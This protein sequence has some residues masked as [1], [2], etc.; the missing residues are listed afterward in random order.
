[1]NPISNE[2]LPLVLKITAGA[3]LCFAM[4]GFAGDY[5]IQDRALWTVYI[6]AAALTAFVAC[7]PQLPYHDRSVLSLYGPLFVLGVVTRVGTIYVGQFFNLGL[8]STAVLLFIACCVAIRPHPKQ[9]Y[10]LINV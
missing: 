8:A 10:Q 2:N 5:L 6:A 4:D 7:F 9:R 1:M 3:M